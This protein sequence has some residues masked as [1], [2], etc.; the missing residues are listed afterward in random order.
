[1]NDQELQHIITKSRDAKHGGF[2]ALSTGEK[3][4][5]ALVLNRPDWLA[6]MNYTLAEAIER[7]GLVWLTLIPRAAREL[8]YEDERAAGKA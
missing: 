5:A 7:V 8:E 4:A 2:G 3:L 1:M 6:E